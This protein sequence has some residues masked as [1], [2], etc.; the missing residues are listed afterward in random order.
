VPHKGQQHLI[1]AA[2]L[3]VK[4]V[5]DVRFVILGDG[6]LREK[7]EKQIKDAHLERHVFLAGFRPDALEL[8]KDFD[9][10][11]MSSVSEGMCTALVDAMAASKP[12]VATAAGG[13]PEVMVDGDT[14]FLVAA[15]D[16]EAMAAKL[17]ILL[18]DP[19]LRARMG[20]AALA[21]ARERFTVER[22]VEGTSAVYERLV[23]TPRAA[24]TASRAA[25]G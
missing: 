5:P 25:R 13:I 19:A 23:G 4:Q 1:D 10:F 18:K 6:E 3:V 2:A 11:A 16:H 22:M 15:R 14:G 20:E 21:R 9:I 24:G 8:T 17:V 7:L 12:A